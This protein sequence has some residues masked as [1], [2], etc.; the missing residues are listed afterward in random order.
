M[1]LLIVEDDTKLVRALQRGLEREG[2]GVDIAV[3]GDEAVAMATAAA[4][5]AIVLDLML[6]GRDGFSVCES[7]REDGRSTPV[8]MLTART[9]VKDRIRGLDAGAD[10]YLV[11]PFDFGELLARLRALHRRGLAEAPAVFVIGELRV[12]PATRV[13]T[14]R[15]VEVELTAREFDVLEYLAGRPGR[16]VSRTELLEQV[17][18]EDYDGSPNITDVYVGYLRRKLGR[19][20]IRTVRGTGFRLEPG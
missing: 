18:D 12:D 4:Y 3:D 5:D 8:L 14:H 16:V 9:G 11:K 2:Y 13:A 20:L 17:W 7:L 10:D 1:R 6:P 19:E 15:G